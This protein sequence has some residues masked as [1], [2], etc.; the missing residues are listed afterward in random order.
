ML[1]RVPDRVYRVIVGPAAR[2]ED[3]YSDKASGRAVRVLTPET[4]LRHQGFSAWLVLESA[5]AV[6]ARYGR[7]FGFCIAV[8]ASPPGALF[9]PSRNDH[10]HVTAY[11]DPASFLLGVKE[12]LLPSSVRLR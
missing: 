8:V 12:I 2:I 11:G 6:S 9:W 5:V 7:Y 1:R 10:K 4:F 3:F